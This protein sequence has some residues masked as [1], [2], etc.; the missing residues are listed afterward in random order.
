MLLGSPKYHQVLLRMVRKALN[1]G[2]RAAFVVHGDSMLPT[3]RDGEQI[4]LSPVDS[5]NLR[6]GDVVAYVDAGDQIIIHRIVMLAQTAV[7]TRGDNRSQNDPPVA[8]SQI[9]GKVEVPTANGTAT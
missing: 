7:I 5:N 9:I 1:Q 8:L 2:R 3:F 4:T 6:L